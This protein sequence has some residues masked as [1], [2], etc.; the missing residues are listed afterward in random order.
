MKNTVKLKKRGLGASITKLTE[1]TKPFL[2]E[3][4]LP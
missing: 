1:F 3:R 4:L 2:H